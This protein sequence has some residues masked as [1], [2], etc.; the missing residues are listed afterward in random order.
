MNDAIPFSPNQ[1]THPRPVPAPFH[2][3]PARQAF[4]PSPTDPPG[5]EPHAFWIQIRDFLPE[6]LT[7]LTALDLGYG[8]GALATEL[9]QRGAEVD[10]VNPDAASLRDTA[11]VVR[12]ASLAHRVHMYHGSLYDLAREDRHYDIVLVVDVLRLLRYPLLALDIAAA[13]ARRCLIFAGPSLPDHPREPAPPDLPLGQGESLL[14]PG[15]PRVAFVEN[16][17]DGDASAWW[18]PNRPAVEAML[19]SAGLGLMAHP[20]ED[21]YLCQPRRSVDT[22]SRSIHAERDAATGVLGPGLRPF[23]PGIEIPDP[24]TAGPAARARGAA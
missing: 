9:A 10:I 1:A 15:W 17:S 19:R 8:K 18:M 16:S 13:L 7:G 12:A 6:N 14:L 3:T 11:A 2:G 23:D 24:A 4:A 5:R 20:A 22:S 21:V